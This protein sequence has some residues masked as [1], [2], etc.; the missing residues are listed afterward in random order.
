MR[1]A[2]AGSSKL[3]LPLAA[4]L[5][6]HTGLFVAIVVLTTAEHGGGETT[7]VASV[8]MPLPVV[9]TTEVPREQE[10]LEFD[11]VEHEVESD[12]PRFDEEEIV[13]EEAAFEEPAPPDDTDAPRADLFERL[14]S[15]SLGGPVAPP[16]PQDDVARPEDSEPELPAIDEPESDAPPELLEAPPPRYPTLAVRR[17]YEG[18]VLLL[19]VVAADG[20]VRDVVV[21]ESSGHDVLDGAAVDAVRTWRFVRGAPDREA[22]H[23][24]TFRLD[25]QG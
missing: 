17:K 21:E 18:S 11:E 12:L 3:G 5:V 20:S 23:R 25:E 22:R 8:E 14:P 10:E 24:V 1:A 7:R 2:G 6:V 4:S 15:A 9:E 19:V 16:P 13:E